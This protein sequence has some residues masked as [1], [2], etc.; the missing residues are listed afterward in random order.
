MKMFGIDIDSS[1]LLE[2]IWGRG[3]KEAKRLK[4]KYGDEHGIYALNIDESGIPEIVSYSG[5]FFRNLLDKPI[6]Y[7]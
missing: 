7:M 1:T 5:A 3:D 6:T 2:D 4:K